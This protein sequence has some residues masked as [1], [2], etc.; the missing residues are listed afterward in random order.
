MK[1]LFVFLFVLLCSM[2]LVFAD[3]STSGGSQSSSGSIVASSTSSSTNMLTTTTGVLVSS[4][5]N[6]GSSDDSVSDDTEMDSTL[7]TSLPEV[8]AVAYETVPALAPT[9]QVCQP[10]KDHVKELDLL[11]SKLKYESTM[12]QNEVDN[13][14]DKIND[15]KKAMDSD[16]QKCREQTK[17]T[18]KEKVSQTKKTR[19][20]YED[21]EKLEYKRD[22]YKNLLSLSDE[23]L[24]EKG[25]TSGRE[26]IKNII[27]ELQRSIDETKAYFEKSDEVESATSTTTGIAVPTLYADDDTGEVAET[28]T[29]SSES[30]SS[31]GL[32]PNQVVIADDELELTRVDHAK[33]LKL[34]PVLIDSGNDISVHYKEQ[35]SEV[36]S[37]DITTEDKVSKLK[38][39]RTEIDNLIGELIRS[40]DVIDSS[41]MSEL[42]EEIKI[43]PG[44]INMGD[45]NVQTIGKKITTRIKNQELNIRPTETSVVMEDGDYEVFADGLSV[46][47]EKLKFD[48][49]EIKITASQI[50]EKITDVS[51]DKIQLVKENSKVLYQIDSEKQKKLLGFIPVK[52]KS[53]ITVDAEDSELDM[54]NVMEEVPWYDFM[55]TN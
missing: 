14:Y 2:T 12:D 22:W 46:E 9:I 35:L 40:N 18:I 33:D 17:S 4:Q 41:D 53:R 26:E 32:K 27:N 45:V 15:L 48:G 34:R 20:S 47:G 52:V 38:D 54:S 6:I 55:T 13:I 3:V 11:L 51:P 49:S 10:S 5:Q 21:L 37:E 31:S 7:V 44:E 8:K 43:N 19:Y 50:M 23:E 25:Y 36:M 30:S 28:T 24:K 39:L 42:V 29:S 1:K 16:E